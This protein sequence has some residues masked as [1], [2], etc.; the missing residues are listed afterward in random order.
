MCCGFILEAF[1]RYLFL[2]RKIKP[3]LSSPAPIRWIGAAINA[4]MIRFCRDV[5]VPGAPFVYF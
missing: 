4:K 1:S 5:P 2:L 3:M